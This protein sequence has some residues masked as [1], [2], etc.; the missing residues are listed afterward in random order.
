MEAPRI[1][2][3]TPQ[4]LIAIGTIIS[5][6]LLLKLKSERTTAKWRASVERRLSQM[7]LTLD[8]ACP[9]LRKEKS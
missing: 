8:K 3:L 6:I 2:N 9:L 7:E 4:D 5:P 1:M